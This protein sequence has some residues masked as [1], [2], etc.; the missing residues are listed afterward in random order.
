MGGARRTSASTS[1]SSTTA[2]TSPATTCATR[3]ATI[4]H[5]L[6]EPE[7]K[8]M[9]EKAQT[10]R[11]AWAPPVRRADGAGRGRRGR[12]ARGRAEPPACTPTARRAARRPRRSPRRSSPACARAP[13]SSTRSRSTSPSTTGCAT[14]R[15]W[16]QS[17]N[18]SNEASDESVQALVDAV[19]G[20]YE[21]ARR[22]Y[23]LKAKL[24]GVDRL[25]DYD[26]MAPV[27]TDEEQPIAWPEAQDDGARLLPLVLAASSATSSRSSSTSR[28][29]DAP[30]RAHKRGGAFCAYTVPSRPPVRAAQLDGAPARRA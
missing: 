21:I 6:S 4:P 5:L 30:V 23:R 14:T 8:L 12:A 3:A 9:A 27:I 17:R 24:L 16:V 22:W 26:R 18:L 19:Q 29:I 7:E 11:S 10:G 15:R 20:R 13:T 28:W 2:S 25:A 1:C